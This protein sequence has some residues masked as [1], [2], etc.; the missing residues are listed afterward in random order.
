MTDFFA[1]R[2]DIELTPDGADFLLCTGSV[3]IAQDIHAVLSTLRGDDR[4]NQDAGMDLFADPIVRTGELAKITAKV[5]NAVQGIPGVISCKV[6]RAAV[7]PS[8]REAVISCITYTDFGA[9]PDSVRI[10]SL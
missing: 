1:V 4:Y 6:I 9:I 5:V 10:G 3:R 2:G 8:T 7:D